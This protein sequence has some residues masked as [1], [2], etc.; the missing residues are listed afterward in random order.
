MNKNMG[1]V[2]R[3]I[4]F[5]IALVIAALYF[6][7]DISGVLGIVLGIIAIA[8]LIT[9]LVGY[10]PLYVPLKISTCKRPT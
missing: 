3:G 5:I 4:R 10:C 7:G 1:G 2:D 8:F 6:R 9:S